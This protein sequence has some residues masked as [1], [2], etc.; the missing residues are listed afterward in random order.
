[1]RFVC[2]ADDGA[3]AVKLADELRPNVLLLDISM[4]VMTGLE[5]ARLIRERRPDIRVIM[6]S[7]T[8]RRHTL[9]RLSE[10]VRTATFSRD[11]RL[12]SSESHTG[13]S[14]NRAR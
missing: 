3:A 6:V 8:Q 12:F 2:E 13:R 7:N 10:S 14:R 11:R 9:R 5:A 4:P 1:M